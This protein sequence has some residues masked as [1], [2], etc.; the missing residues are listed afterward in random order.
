[1]QPEFSARQ[2][3]FISEYPIDQNGT[4][5]AIRAG[6]SEKTA[7]EQSARLLAKVSIRNAIDERL[8]QKAN[9]CNITAEFVLN[10]I[11]DLAQNAKQES[12]K[13]KAFELL[14]KYHKL[15][16]DRVESQND[17]TLKVSFDGEVA[18]WAK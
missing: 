2:L 12:T 13:V 3:A 11:L 15:F 10:G 9:V 1:M 16:T 5:A 6:Y 7:N 14:G 17:T 8:Q 18:D 4:Q